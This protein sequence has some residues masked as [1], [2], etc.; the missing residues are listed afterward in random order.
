M[1]LSLIGLKVYSYRCADILGTAAVVPQCS[2]ILAS[3][4]NSHY[5]TKLLLMN[6]E[7]S[8]YAS[9]ELYVSPETAVA[10]LV[11][12]SGPLAPDHDLRTASHEPR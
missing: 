1:Q 9:S 4:R 3:L 10:V 2:N 8:H 5:G 7:R 6:G 12:Q 11:A